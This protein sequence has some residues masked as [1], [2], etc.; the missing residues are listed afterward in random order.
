LISNLKKIIKEAL[1]E[2]MPRGDITTNITISTNHPVQARIISKSKGVICGLEVA[3]KVFLMVD[4][5]LVVKTQLQ[6][7]AY[8]KTNQTILTIRGN[9]KSILK[10]ER[11]ALN[12]LGFMSG[13]STKTNELSLLI[14]KFKTKVCCTRKTLPNLRN[15]QKYAVIVGGGTNNRMNLSD[16]IFI[17]DNHIADN[18]LETLI[19][20]VIKKNKLKKLITVEVDNLAQLK[21]IKAYKINRVL[22][23]NMTPAN[24]KNGIKLLPKNIE[25]EASGN[26]NQ[27]NIRNYAKSGV[28]RISM[29]ALTHTI[30]NFDFSLEI[31]N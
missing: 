4:K 22:F 29:G 18:N 16:E 20:A 10:A 6:D 31:K 7:G 17:K 13:I 30:T 25:T 12:F 9:K 5:Q 24:I 26:I 8:I 14:K 27:S 28:Q 21:K 3:K 15:L 23:D 19:P 2:D 11:T 1:R